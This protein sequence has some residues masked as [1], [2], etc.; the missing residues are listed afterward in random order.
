MDVSSHPVTYYLWGLGKVT[1]ASWSLSFPIGELGVITPVLQGCSSCGW[2]D[3]C[4]V[5]SA[6]S[7]A[8]WAR[9][10]RDS[11][12]PPTPWRQDPRKPSWAGALFPDCLYS[13]YST[14]VQSTRTCPCLLGEAWLLIHTHAGTVIRKPGILGD[15]LALSTSQKGVSLIALVRR[16]QCR[17][18][19][20]L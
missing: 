2:G 10:K 17:K 14:A 15:E 20:W 6:G 7:G 19:K 18:S 4:Q 16:F 8:E 3:L 1:L 5:L 12:S 11:R 13:G 9:S